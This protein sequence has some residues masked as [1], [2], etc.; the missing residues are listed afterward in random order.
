MSTVARADRFYSRYSNP[1]VKA[2]EDAVAQLEGAE[3]A[4]AF[5]SG[6][7]ALAT[8][9]FALCSPGDHIVAQRHIYSGTQLL[10]Q[11][12]C[13]RFGID[14]TLVDGVDAG[15]A[16]RRRAA[17]PH[18]AR[19]RRDAG[20]PAAGPDRPG[21]AG[22]HHRPLHAGRL[23]LRHA[24]HPAAPRSRRR[25]RAALRHQG[26]RRPQRRHARRGRR[27]CRAARRH[28]GLLGAPRRLRLAVRRH[29]RP[30][31]HPDPS[32]AHRPPERHGA[33]P[34][35]GAREAP[36]GG[37]GEL[38]G[39]GVASPARP[40]QAADGLRRVGAVGRSGRWARGRAGGSSRACGWPRWPRRSAGPRRW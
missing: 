26:D 11:G 16:G 13:A 30:A 37:V 9:V 32:G 40:G 29:Q 23:H 34:G 21:R 6:M 27:W 15:R 25:P 10:L 1:S 35:R 12:P 22:R 3:A 8:T 28:L 7:G 20:Q 38:P 24:D 19:H 2:F 39:A 33:A 5:A 31:R 18:D 17:G 36:G 14:V 4:L